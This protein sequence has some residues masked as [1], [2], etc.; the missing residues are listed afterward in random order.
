MNELLKPTWGKIGMLKINSINSGYGDLKILHDI[1][2][3]LNKGE[4][5]SVVGSNGAGKS[6][7][8][9]TIS[10]LVRSYSGSILFNGQDI[11]KFPAHTIAELGVAYVPEGRRLFSKLSVVE[12]LLVG[13]YLKHVRPQRKKNFEEIYELFP[14][15]SERRNQLAGTLSGGEQ[16]MLAIARGLM[17]C[18]KLLLLDEPSLGIAPII[19]DR[20]FEVILKLKNIG[21]TILI[22]EQNVKRALGVSDKGMVI[23]TGQ[24]VMEGKS[25]EML[26]SDEIKKAYLGM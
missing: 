14:I 5:L 12:N 17:A 16:Q 3:H 15:L 11:A 8:M 9:K 19:V 23:Q 2:L 20:I 22:S 1:S 18:P 21:L 6:T 26:E 10:G 25:Q 4:V 24:I 13:S 7:L